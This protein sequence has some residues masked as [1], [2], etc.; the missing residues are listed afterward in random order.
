MRNKLFFLL[1]L[2]L[3]WFVVAIITARPCA[4]K[5][6]ALAAAPSVWLLLFKSGISLTPQQ[7]QFAG[8]PA[9]F[10]VGFLLL[11][12][13][14]KPRVIIIYSIVTTFILWFALLGL[15][16][17]GAG[18]KIPWAVPVWLLCCFNLSL[19]LLPLFAFPIKLLSKLRKTSKQS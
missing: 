11:K 1:G 6:Y 4:G 8:L 15:A 18:I 16:S 13:K 5:A 7:M 19:C 12:F 17:Q 9:M 14:M 2:P 3:V 10:L